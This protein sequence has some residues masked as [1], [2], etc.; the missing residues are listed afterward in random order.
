MP[1]SYLRR[2]ALLAV[3]ML[4]F[5]S[6]LQAAAPTVEDAL[7]LAP[8]QAGIEFDTPTADQAKQCKISPE[9]IGAAT[10]WVVRDPNGVILR[11]FSDSNGDNVV[12]TWSYYKNGL[13]VYREPTST[14]TARPTSTAGSTPAARAGASTKTKTA[15]STRGSKFLLKKLPRK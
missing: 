1:L 15:R 10:A 5:S 8:L 4:S 14:S 2:S 7:K 9:K 11:Q 13:E 12:D 3:P 6:S